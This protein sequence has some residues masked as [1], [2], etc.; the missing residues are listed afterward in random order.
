MPS[1]SAGNPTRPSAVSTNCRKPAAQG[2]PA[3]HRPEPA[4]PEPKI[5]NSINLIEDTRTV[6]VAAKT[7]GL[8]WTQ[9][10]E[11]RQRDI[12]IAASQKRAE[13]RIAAQAKAAAVVAQASVTTPAAAQTI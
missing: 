9:A 7:Q 1:A 4:Q 8:T 6:A 11:Q 13:A 10:Y 3:E 5:E 2:I 12:R